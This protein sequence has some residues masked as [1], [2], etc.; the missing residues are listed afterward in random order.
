M[1]QR[2]SYLSKIWGVLG[3]LGLFAILLVNV[4]ALSPADAKEPTALGQGVCVCEGCCPGYCEECGNCMN[5]T[6]SGCC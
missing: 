3:S 2:Q 5:C 6:Q 4:M 1:Y